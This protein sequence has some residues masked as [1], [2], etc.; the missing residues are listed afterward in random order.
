MSI[1]ADCYIFWV[2]MLL[3]LKKVK[4]GKYLLPSSMCN[5]LEVRG[6]KF[7]ESEAFVAS[8]VLDPRFNWSLDHPVFNLRLRDRGIVS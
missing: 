2:K 3:K 4:D 1:L 6:K 8:L 7:F 5:N